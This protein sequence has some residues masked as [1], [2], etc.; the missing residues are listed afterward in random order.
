MIPGYDDDGN[1]G[2]GEMQQG[3]GRGN[4]G[5]A[6]GLG[7]VE[8]V[9]GMDDQVDML[10][11]GVLADAVEAVDEVIPPPRS[12]V[13]WAHG[14]PRA[15]VRVGGMQNLPRGAHA[16]SLRTKP[17]RW[18]SDVWIMLDSGWSCLT[19]RQGRRTM[20]TKSDV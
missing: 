13:A 6:A 19:S 4:E 1:A 15:D 7:A 16:V 17:G 5:P 20:C 9:A 3:F 11:G 2:C 18:K 12:A 10:L 14:Q 8:Q